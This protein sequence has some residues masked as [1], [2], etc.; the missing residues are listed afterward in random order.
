MT[1]MADAAVA[2]LTAGGV[3]EVLADFERM[4]AQSLGACPGVHRQKMRQH[5]SGN[6]IRH[7]G[8]KMRSE[9]VQL[10]CRATMRRPADT[11][12]A[13][14]TAGAAKPREPHRTRAEQR[15][16][17]MKPPILDVTSTAAGQAVWPQNHMPV[18][19]RGH[20]RLL[21]A[22]QKLLPLGQRQPQIRDMGSRHGST[23]CAR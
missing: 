13:T 17:L 18:G 16:D 6:T 3:A 14:T 2:G 20:H 22:S 1:V 8:G 19:L 5:T 10:W 15:R 9:L 4:A 7:Q 23:C 21:H 11:R 12:R